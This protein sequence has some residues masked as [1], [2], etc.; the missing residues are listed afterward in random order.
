MPSVAPRTKT[1]SRESAAF[2][3]A[4]IFSRASSNNSVERA[5][6]R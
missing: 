6:N 5:L 4:L 1:I 2:K 3:N